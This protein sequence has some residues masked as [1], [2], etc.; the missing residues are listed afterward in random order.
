MYEC[1]FDYNN[2]K[3]G[4]ILLSIDDFKKLKF[5][6]KKTITLFFSWLQKK[7]SWRNRRKTTQSSIFSKKK[8]ETRINDHFDQ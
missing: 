3:K 2:G 4:E 1:H 7:M 5:R 6:R 8:K